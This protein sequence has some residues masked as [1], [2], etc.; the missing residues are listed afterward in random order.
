MSGYFKNLPTILYDFGNGIKEEIKDITINVRL[1]KSVREKIDQIY[2]EYELNGIQFN[3]DQDIVESSTSEQT[4]LNKQVFAY[5]YTIQDNETL[6][7]ISYK[8]YG[9]SYY[10]WVIMLVNGIYDYINDMPLNN[11]QLIDYCIEKYGIDHIHDIKYYKHKTLNLIVD[12]T[13]YS[14]IDLEA[15]S[16]FD[17]ESEINEKKRLIRIPPVD[18]VAQ[19]IKEQA[20]LVK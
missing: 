2:K 14:L 13:Q 17:Y 15:I 1:I 5:Y 4:A 18:M 19:I 12:K 7:I 16:N 9:N 20:K 10:H 6:D 11:S 8:V 3:Y